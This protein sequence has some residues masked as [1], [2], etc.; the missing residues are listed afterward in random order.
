[1]WTTVIIELAFATLVAVYLL[2]RN[3]AA[4]R[5]AREY[6]A[7]RTLTAPRNLPIRW[8]IF[9]IICAIWFVLAFY[10][11]LKLAGRV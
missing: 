5:K 10:A 8:A 1:M 11:V 2:V 7:G 9:G 3:I 6:R 4:T